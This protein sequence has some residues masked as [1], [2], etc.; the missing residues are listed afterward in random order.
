MERRIHCSIQILLLITVPSALPIANLNSYGSVPSVTP[1]TFSWREP[2][3]PPPLSDSTFR[4]GFPTENDPNIPLHMYRGRRPPGMARL[5]EGEA[6]DP[7][8]TLG[9]L[10]HTRFAGDGPARYDRMWEIRLGQVC[11]ALLC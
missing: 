3:S 6:P 9:D 11:L 8:T 10:I 4:Q 5:K 1:E 7:E 2:Y